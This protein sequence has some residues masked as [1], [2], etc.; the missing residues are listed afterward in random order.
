MPYDDLIPFATPR[1]CEYIAAV[2]EHGSMR[3]AASALGVDHSSI[4]CAMRRLKKRAAR[5]D[6][7]QHVGAAPPGYRLRGV[8][9]LVNAAGQTIMQWQKTAVD[10]ESRLQII[11]EA[12][13][14][15]KETH[16]RRLSPLKA[17]PRV[18]ADLLAVYPLADAH[19]GM[20]AW[21]DE[22][23]ENFDL[24]LAESMYR[25]TFD[26]LIACV[27][28]AETALFVNLGDYVHADGKGTT[29]KG[30]PVDVD[31]R[32]GKIALAG[33]RL[34][35]YIVDRLLQRHGQVHMIIKGGNHDEYTGLLLALCFDAIYE[36]EP[37]VR[38]STSP[39]VHEV[40]EFGANLIGAAH[41]DKGSLGELPG[42]MA[43]RWPE[44]WGRTKHRLWYTGH[45][46]QDSFVDHPGCPVET[47]R[48]LAPK[49]AFAAARYESFRDLKC[50]IW[51][52][53]D[54][55]ITR[56]IQG[57]VQG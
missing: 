45:V 44:A 7:G 56:L 4:S 43:A 39:A 21:S 5:T 27:P 2:Q 54:G 55:R 52:R 10:H 22:C 49:D 42:I 3:R 20:L 15:I 11:R 19:L 23:G 28:G 1:Q 24:S 41:G 53:T 35:R 38:V 36:R 50:D 40:H 13:E 6:P 46:H 37:R 14:E 57:P 26:R 34:K 30:T 25:A 33:I 29:T 9:T 17:P 12:M 16:S 8:S 31:S 51:H 48:S 18:D 47:L 32:P